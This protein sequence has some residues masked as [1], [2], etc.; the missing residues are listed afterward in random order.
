MEGVA[1]ATGFRLLGFGI[2]TLVLNFYWPD[3]AYRLPEGLPEILDGLRE[4]Y[5]ASRSEDDALLWGVDAYLPIP[6]PS[7]VD[8]SGEGYRLFEVARVQTTHH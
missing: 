6:N 4:A 7:Q 1:R 5:L 3:G 8:F 2:D